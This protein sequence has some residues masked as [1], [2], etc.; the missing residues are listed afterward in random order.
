MIREIRTFHCDGHPSDEDIRQA[1]E[2][3][4][5]SYL[6]VR[7]TWFIKYSGEYEVLVVK[8]DTPATVRDR[9]PKIYGI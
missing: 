8:D 3:V 6:I 4:G 1:L 7:L 2:I 5:D 9:L